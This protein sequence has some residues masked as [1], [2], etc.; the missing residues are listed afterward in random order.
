MTFGGKILIDDSRCVWVG[1]SNKESE[2][3]KEGK[4][5]KEMKGEIWQ[6]FWEQWKKQNLGMKRIEGEEK[7]IAKK[8]KNKPNQKPWKVHKLVWN[9]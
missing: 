6:I 8:G 9:K 7:W 1:V 3:N 5:E 4:Y 2:R